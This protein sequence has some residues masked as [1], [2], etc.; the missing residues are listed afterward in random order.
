[1]KKQMFKAIRRNHF[2]ILLNKK[3][4]NLDAQK[5]FKVMLEYDKLYGRPVDP[6]IHGY[7]DTLVGFQMGDCYDIFYQNIHLH[8]METKESVITRITLKKD[9]DSW[10]IG[11]RFSE[12]NNENDI[13]EV[14]LTYDI[15]VLGGLRCTNTIDRTGNWN[16]YVYKKLCEIDNIIYGY[17]KESEFNKAYDFVKKENDKSSS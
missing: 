11:S 9:E 14:F 17:T 6:V 2:R 7:N 3:L 10:V 12:G 13:M 16:E 5:L 15:E 8:Y 4:R 1:M